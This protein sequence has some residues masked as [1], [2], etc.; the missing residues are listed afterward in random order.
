[1]NPEDKPVISPKEARPRKDHSFLPEHRRHGDFGKGKAR[2]G[3]KFDRPSNQNKFQT[4]G[5]R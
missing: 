1:M 5:N 2:K 3:Q 4:R